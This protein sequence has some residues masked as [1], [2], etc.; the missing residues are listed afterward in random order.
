MCIILGYK[1]VFE[2]SN[3][4]K[5]N[6]NNNNNNDSNKIHEVYFKHLKNF[7]IKKSIVRNDLYFYK[8]SFGSYLPDPCLKNLL[9]VAF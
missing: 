8:F 6:T 7:Y 9:I 3:K 2:L 4:G 5:Y 1:G